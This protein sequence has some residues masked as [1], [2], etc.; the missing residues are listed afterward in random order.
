M[1][2]QTSICNIALTRI[3]HETITDIT[4][5]NKAARMCSVH[6]ADTLE[7]M[8]R[9]HPWN[10]AVRRVELAQLTA[11]PEYEFAYQYTL[12]SDCLKVLRTEDDSAGYYTEYRIESLSTGERVLVTD[13]GTCKLEYI[14]SVTDP[15]LMDA[16]FRD[17]FSARLSAELAV[18]LTDN[19]SLAEKLWQIGE[20]KLRLA[21][22]MD[23]QEGTP[24]DIIADQWL[25]ARF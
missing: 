2:S 4:E 20:E 8:L 24:R 18:V 16:L 7:S 9:A 23:A 19:A 15:N 5:D 11:T 1:A 3:G 17:A 6:Y 12:P 25:Q 10:F 22:T 13:A 14:A 21:M